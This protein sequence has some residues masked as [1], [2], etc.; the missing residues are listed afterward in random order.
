IGG[1]VNN[2][3]AS[4]FS[5]AGA[6]G[7]ARKGAASLYNGSVGLILDNSALDANSWSL[8][9]QATPKPSY[10][11]LQ[12]LANIGGPLTIPHLMTGRGASFFVGYQAV[13]NRNATIGSALMPTADQR[14]AAGI[15][16]SQVSPQALA[17]LNLYPLPNF[18]G[19][20]RF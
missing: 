19:G 10:S 18:T 17:L 6:F 11:R 2:G 5:Q 7:N 8:T 3:S 1:S 16:S 13:R 20:G 4:V 9:G 14:S 12:Y 15:P